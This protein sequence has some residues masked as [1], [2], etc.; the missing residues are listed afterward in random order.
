M[1]GIV[2]AVSGVTVLH[3]ASPRAR[4]VGH[5]CMSE[6]AAL[7]NGMWLRQMQT[8]VIRFL[9]CGSGLSVFCDSGSVVESG[10]RKRIH[11]HACPLL[12][13]ASLK[14]IFETCQPRDEVLRGELKE[15]V[16]AARLRDVMDHKADPVYRDPATFFENTYPTAGLKTLLRDAL[17]RLTG[18][19]GGKNAVIRLETA[20]GGGK[21]HSLIA[22]YHVASGQSP[23]GRLWTCWATSSDCLRRA[24]SRSL[25]WSAPISTRPSAFIT[26][27]APGP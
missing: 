9:R 11:L 7:P 6:G 23:R 20:F 27:M 24:R 22:L 2:P 15:D 4:T 3:V 5:L 12:L 8:R 13:E 17:G 1:G 19:A 18:D 26:P 25:A 21:T 14:A 16:F 10:A